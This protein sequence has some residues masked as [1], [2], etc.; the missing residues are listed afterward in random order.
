MMPGCDRDKT[1]WWFEMVV[2]TLCLF[3]LSWE[4]WDCEDADGVNPRE[5]SINQAA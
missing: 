2:R 4:S 1:Q 5:V 3:L